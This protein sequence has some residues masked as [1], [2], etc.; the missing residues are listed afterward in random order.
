MKSWVKKILKAILVIFVLLLLSLLCLPYFYKDNI[1][2]YIK[3]E[4]SNYI[5]ADL[6]FD[7]IDV[8][9]LKSFPKLTVELDALKLIGKN[10][11][12]GVELINVQKVAVEVDLLDILIHNKYQL[13][14]LNVNRPI[15]NLITLEDG[16][17]NYDIYITDDENQSSNTVAESSL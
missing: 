17:V 1:A 13:N 3:N 6:V 11:F 12:K 14:K 15:V 16:S 2:E 4:S 5:D 9:A 10:K 8:F 7:G